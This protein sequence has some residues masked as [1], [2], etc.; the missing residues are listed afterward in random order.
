[1][2][3]LTILA[4]FIYCCY[5]I[6]AQQTNL[7]NNY[8]EESIIEK[9]STSK[10]ARLN[11][12]YAFK[13]NGEQGTFT[14]GG[15]T[16]ANT[17]FFQ[18]EGEAEGLH[19]QLRNFNL[20]MQSSFNNDKIST[21]VNVGY[22]GI[23]NKFELT[24]AALNIAFHPAFNF[25]AG[26]ILPPMGYFNQNGDA[27]IANFIDAPIAS[28]SIIPTRWSEVG[29]GLNGLINPTKNIAFT[30]EIYAVN[31]LQNGIVD[32]DLPRTAI[33][34]GKTDNVFS[35]DN[36]SSLSYTGR[37]GILINKFGEL[38]VSYYT[39]QYNTTELDEIEI[40][41]PRNIS[42]M[43]IDAQLL[44]AKLSLKAEGVIA[45]I[46]I[47]EGLGQLFGNKQTGYHLEA[48]YPIIENINLFGNKKNR[49]N[50]NI[51]YEFAD[52]NAGS[53]EQT[54]SNIS[55]EVKCIRSGLSLQIDKKT[56]LKANYSYLLQSDILGNAAKTGGIQFGFATYF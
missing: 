30:Y 19:L 47:Y 41:E 37:V 54:G 3:L 15:Y 46:D 5:T 16:E 35:A 6:N 33:D 48:N 21:I 51:R 43:A 10:D 49:I 44:L 17:Q 9:T 56:M 7:D 27:P 36:N 38:G 18:T 50:A 34:L 52:Y 8:S 23:S 20:F 22:N 24:E 40:D 1:M 26:V 53:F 32:N 4:G 13:S 39:G 42:L 28:T 29:F 45:R 25:R 12:P 14:V 2:K 55:D 11:R 31:G